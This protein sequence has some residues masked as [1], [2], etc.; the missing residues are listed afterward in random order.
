[1]RALAPVSLRGIRFTCSDAQRLPDGG[2]PIDDGVQVLDLY[3]LNG[4]V[5]VN[6]GALAAVLVVYR[7]I[8]W[9]LLR[10]GRTRWK[11]RRNKRRKEKS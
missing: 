1:V 9:W 10:L 6:L 7:L 5:R 4:S 8:A 11:G 3:R 2:C